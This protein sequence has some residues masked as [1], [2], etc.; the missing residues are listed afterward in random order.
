M[1]VTAEPITGM[2]GDWLSTVA[3]N[4]TGNVV[5]S[6]VEVHAR[7]EERQRGDHVH[8]QPART[9]RDRPRGRVAGLHRVA[10]W[11]AAIHFLVQLVTV[12]S[13]AH[14]TLL[15]GGAARTVPPG[16]PGSCGYVATT[17]AVG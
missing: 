10:L 14:L 12:T 15:S 13:V 11:S 7:D 9:P 1:N 16:R 3:S 4:I 17:A 8:P 5:T 6:A 2:I